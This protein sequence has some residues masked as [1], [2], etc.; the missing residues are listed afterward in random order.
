MWQRLESFNK[1]IINCKSNFKSS[2]LADHL[3]IL[4][5]GEVE[6]AMRHVLDGEEPSNETLKN[7]SQV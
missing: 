4:T 2:T 7:Y 3:S 6:T 1:C 5:G